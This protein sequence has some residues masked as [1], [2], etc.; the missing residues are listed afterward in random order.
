MVPS[1]PFLPWSTGTAT[2]TRMA[3]QLPSGCCSS[4]PWTLRSGLTTQG[5]AGDILLPAAVRHG[6]GV[7][8]V[9]Q[10]T[11]ILG[12]AHTDDL[13]LFTAGGNAERPDPGSRRDAADFMLAGYAAEKQRHAQ[14]S[15]LV[16]HGGESPF[17]PVTV[18]RVPA[19]RQNEAIRCRTGAR[20]DGEKDKA[21][22]GRQRRTP[23]VRPRFAT[24]GHVRFIIPYLCR[25][26]H[27][28][29]EQKGDFS[30][31]F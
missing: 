16:G 6:G 13:I 9:A 12:D 29:C 21:R 31:I 20:H 26:Y 19:V 22:Q 7:A 17:R 25:R 23:A 18:L 30:G 3:F 10:P 27:R 5:A 14:R 11:A 4:R 24:E 2:S 15:G 8:V 1:S 28:F